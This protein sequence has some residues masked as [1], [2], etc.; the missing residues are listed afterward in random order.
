MGGENAVGSNAGSA[1]AGGGG[2]GGD[3][4]KEEAGRQSVQTSAMFLTER[5]SKAKKSWGRM[6][7][8]GESARRG[9]ASCSP[10]LPPARFHSIPV[11][12]SKENFRVHQPTGKATG[13]GVRVA[14]GPTR[15]A[16]SDPRLRRRHDHSL[17]P[18]QSLSSL[19]HDRSRSHHDNRG[20]AREQAANSVSLRHHRVTCRHACVGR[21]RIKDS[22][23]KGHPRTASH[24]PSHVDGPSRFQTSLLRRACG[25]VVRRSLPWAGPLSPFLRHVQFQPSSLL[26]ASQAFD[27]RRPYGAVRLTFV[28]SDSDDVAAA[29]SSNA[30]R[31]TRRAPGGLPKPLRVPEPSSL[32]LTSY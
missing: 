12:A 31:S 18:P 5:E 10:P 9:N 14:L 16:S 21:G 6:W 8:K 11:T 22:R 28:P 25:R 24:R 13:L 2:G 17:L 29:L 4:S 30:Q 3:T 32:L 27:V 26:S 20:S 1:A 7:S 15:R 23:R 19:E